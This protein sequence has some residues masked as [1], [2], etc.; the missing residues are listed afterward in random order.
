[1]ILSLGPMKPPVAL[2]LCPVRLRTALFYRRYWPVPERYEPLF[3]EAPLSYAK[4]VSMSLLRTDV[5][6]AQIAMTGVFDLALTKRLLRAARDGGLLVDVG[7]NAGYFTLL[8][9]SAA[10]RNDC[11]AIEASP[12]NIDRL[13]RNVERN[14]LEEQVSIV[15]TAAGAESGSMRFDLGPTDQTGWGGFASEGSEWETTDVKV[16][17]VDDIVGDREVSFLKVDVEG[18][19]AWVLMGCKR[20]LSEKRVKELHYEQNRPR[21]Q[22]LGIGDDEAARF[23]AKVGYEARPLGDD[24][25]G[26]V[27][28]VA[29]P[30]M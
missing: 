25:M 29:R 24:S 2:R 1:L 10:A 13:R 22:S 15:E 9:A 12:R 11:I 28:W 5:G 6:H 20:M 30:V 23:L 8:W 27:D 19:D 14:K 21:M 18:A 7:A 3:E 17:P 16:V 4:H 26:L